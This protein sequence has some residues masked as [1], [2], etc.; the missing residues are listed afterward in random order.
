MLMVMLMVMLMLMVMCICLSQL[1]NLKNLNILPICLSQTIG[2]SNQM[3]N[4]SLNGTILC[5]NFFCLQFLC[6]IVLFSQ[7]TA[8]S[9]LKTEKF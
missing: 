4:L 1:T 5:F 8:Q 3:I 2:I 7:L 9:H 6:F